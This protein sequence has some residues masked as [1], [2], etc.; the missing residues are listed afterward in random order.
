MKDLYAMGEVLEPLQVINHE[1]SASFALSHHFSRDTNKKGIDRF[2]GS[3][4]PEWARWLFAAE[5]THRKPIE[6]GSQVTRTLDITGSS[7]AEER[8]VVMRKVGSFDP[9]DA[10][11]RLWVETSVCD[12]PTDDERMVGDEKMTPAAL[13][14]LRAP[15]RTRPPP[16]RVA[17]PSLDRQRWW[18]LPPGDTHGRGLPEVARGARARG[19]DEPRARRRRGGMVAHRCQMICRT[20]QGLLLRPVRHPHGEE[21]A[22]GIHAAQR[23]LGLR[24]ACL[25]SLLR[26][27]RRVAPPSPVDA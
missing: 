21:A 5:I 7:V 26:Q 25:R 27:T 15:V 4:I 1:A 6:N 23:R 9:T 22:A 16:G 18:G 20:N 13:R 14:V 24:G 3:G 2:S 8:Y 19:R 10:D 11:S 12:A 17:D